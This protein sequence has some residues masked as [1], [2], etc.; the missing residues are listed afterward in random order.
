MHNNINTFEHVRKIIML[1]LDFHYP[2]APMSK[3]TILKPL[4]LKKDLPFSK[5]FLQ[6]QATKVF[7]NLKDFRTYENITIF[8]FLNLP[9]LDEETYILSF[10]NKLMKP[11]IF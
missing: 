10:K 6:Q 7:E 3:T 9:H 1:F 8:E 4:E 2:L 5:F 11:N